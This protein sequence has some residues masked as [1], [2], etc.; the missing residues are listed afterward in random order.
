LWADF[1]S[2]ENAGLNGQ[3]LLRVRNSLMI[4]DCIAFALLFV[5]FVALERLVE[6]RFV[7]RE[8]LLYKTLHVNIV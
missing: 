5:S 1:Y 6:W 2:G 7:A 8:R 4:Q 3:H